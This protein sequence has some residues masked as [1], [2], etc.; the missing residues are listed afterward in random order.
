[1]KQLSTMQKIQKIL[2][3]SAEADGYK[4]VEQKTESIELFFIKKELDMNRSKSVHHFQ[5]T[6]YKDFVM[7][8]I[9]YRGSSTIQIHP[10]MNEDEMRT[11]VIQAA[12][13]AGFVKNKYYP[14]VKPQPITKQAPISNF[15]GT[16][17][18]DWIPQLTASIFEA[19]TMERGRINSAELFIDKF[20][21]RIVNSEGVD[22]KK[23]HYRG[24]LELI[25][26][27]RESGEEIE[28]Y[29]DYHFA[30]FQPDQFGRVV[31]EMLELSREKALAG[32]TP[33]LN[34]YTI[35]L[36]GEPVRDF[37]HY[38]FIKSA[39]QSVY[40]Q[41]STLKRG[42][43]VQGPNPKGDLI[44][45]RLDPFLGNSS[46]STSFD[47]D[48]MPVDG[49]TIINQGKL[50][51]YWGNTQYCHYLD[52]KP[53]G[54]IHNLVIAAGSKS[55]QDMKLQPY[56]ELLA[57]SDFQM[58]PLTGNFGGEIRLG[59]Y[60]DGKVTSLVTGGSI[61]GDIRDV[62]SQMYL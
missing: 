25:T 49:I 46:V 39:A 4:I 61:S 45:L 55:V 14:L 20:D 15:T 16:I 53:T 36:T 35:L 60:F 9:E 57:F 22:V 23:E 34:R 28:L 62:Q 59:R 21:T 30:S 37:L 12:Y 54:N 52:V 33:S 29:R 5:V 8:G 10:T 40:E 17:L 48:G 41:T 18:A 13:A 44:S 31:R 27:W 56:L 11:A 7:D 47:E 24:E 19:D 3:S 32:P 6:I 58:D 50:L 43:N 51:N 38:Y 2:A 26:N 42:E 1:M